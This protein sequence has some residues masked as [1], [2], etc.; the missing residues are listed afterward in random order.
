MRPLLGFLV[1]A[2]TGSFLTATTPQEK[3]ASQEAKRPGVDGNL[4]VT[5]GMSMI[6]DSPAAVLKLSIANGDLAEAV[7]I[8][9][10]EVLINGKAAGETSLIVWQDGGARLIFDL[11]V[12]MNS[13]RLDA[14]R[15]QIA[16]DF[17]DEDIS[18]TFENDTAF[19]RGTVKDIFEAGRIMAM[20]GSMGPRAVN[21]LHVS[22]PAA[23]PQILLKVRF[24]DVD[25]S[26]SINLGINFAS[27]AFNQVT[28]LSTGQFGGAGVDGSG[29]FNLSNALN[30][31]LFRKDINLGATI[32]ALQ[33]KNLLQMLAEPNVM[34]TS[35]QPASFIDGGKLPVPV[36]ESAVTPGAVTIQFYPY[37]I[38]LYFLPEVTPRGTIHLKVTP[39]VSAPDYSNAVSVAGTT[40]PGFTSRR[41]DT[42]VELEPGQSFVIAGLLDNQTTETLNK[43]P[44]LASLPILGK[45]FQS[46]AK[47]K[48]NSELLVIVTPELVRPIPANQKPPELNFMSS[49]LEP[50][51][52]IPLRQPGVSQTG[53][54]PIHPPN[55]S[56]PV[57]QLIQQLEKQ[58]S[59]PAPQAPNSPSL[60]MP[61]AAPA[62]G[63]GGNG[64]AAGG[65]AK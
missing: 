48:S 29:T 52:R 37:G 41:V 26:Q 58:K 23:Q 55:P 4:Y 62:S 15:Q 5:V 64:N 33:S 24:A 7:A 54:V 25:R 20:V 43:I 46:R 19:V 45:L 2:C 39:E 50:N 21:L 1:V 47:S 61:A 11:T 28:G 53:D 9:P 34:A 38:Q 32:E 56:M 31:L 65:A 57:E 35:G 13:H 8:T 18:I 27:T 36:L 44:G 51:T 14:V 59:N 6:I 42:E 12:R 60:Q 16:R 30:V 49:F 22:I 40:V 17:P 10:K 3:P 63:F